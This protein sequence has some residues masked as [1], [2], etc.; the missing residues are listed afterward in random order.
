MRGELTIT[1]PKG[2]VLVPNTVYMN[3]PVLVGAMLLEADLISLE[4]VDL[5]V[6][7]G[8]AWLAKHHAS[9]DC[10]QKEVVFRITD[11]QR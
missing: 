8:M 1:L 10:F 5:D 2:E 11:D 3:S 7:L 6:I 4:I 9:I